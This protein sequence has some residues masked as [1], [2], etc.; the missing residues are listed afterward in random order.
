MRSHT[1]KLKL[2]DIQW[3]SN[4]SEQFATA[5]LSIRE[6]ADAAAAGMLWTDQRVQRGI[7]PEVTPP[8]SAE[9]SLA[10]GYPNS[11]Q[12][13]FD[14]ARA[15]DMVAKL[16]DGRRLFL[17]P[18]IWNARPGTF[19]AYYNESEHDIYFYSGRIY[20]PDSHHRHQAILKAAALF[21]EA[22]NDYQSFTPERRFTVELYFMGVEDEGEYFFEK[23]QLGRSADKSKAY[24]LSQYDAVAI[25]AK[26]M[27]EKSPSL[28][29]NVNRVTDR[30]TARNPQVVTLSTLRSA[31]QTALDADHV[32]TEQVKP[33]PLLSQ[34][35]MNYSLKSAQS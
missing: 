24:D 11:S 7:K 33:M 2:S 23:N 14:V 31:V 6:I 1:G 5:T 27:I 17:N 4:K 15:D 3:T 35:F 28:T 21:F 9:M 13:V 8:P 25:V 34:R 26:A 32:P 22:P 10:S 16:L 30:L 29:G 20:L 18:L 19:E 12:Y